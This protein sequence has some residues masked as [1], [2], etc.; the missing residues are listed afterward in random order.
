MRSKSRKRKS[1]GSN[2]NGGRPKKAKRKE[3][4]GRKRVQIDNVTEGSQSTFYRRAHE[5]LD[6]VQYNIE[7]LELAVSIGK[8]KLKKKNMPTI[9]EESSNVDIIKHSNESVL[10]F[11]LEHNFSKNTYTALAQDC[12]NKNFSIYPNYHFIQ[13]ELTKCHLQNYSHSEVAVS[14]HMQDILNKTAERLCASVAIDWHDRCLNKL[15]LS[16]TVGFD[17]S[18]GHSDLHQ[19]FNNLENEK[20]DIQLPLFV[21]N[22]LV[23]RLH[24]TSQHGK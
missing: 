10:E 24:S 15:V 14:V 13:N 9:S 1:S 22:M 18:S 20:I 3:K 8:K 21:S 17:S 19:Q 2:K 12:R 16:V 23:I 7:L 11:Y 4:C 5:I 6:Y